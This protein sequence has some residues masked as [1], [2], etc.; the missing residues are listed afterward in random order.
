[1][2]T[3]LLAASALLWNGNGFPIFVFFG[4]LCPNHTA[5][6]FR[7]I[8]LALAGAILPAGG[9]ALWVDL[10]PNFLHVSLLHLSHVPALT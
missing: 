10:D 7:L 8:F 5:R 9:F 3:L 1:M 4:G 2:T 6:L